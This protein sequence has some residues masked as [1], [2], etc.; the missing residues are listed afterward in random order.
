[1]NEAMLRR[2]PL[3]ARALVGLLRLGFKVGSPLSHS[4]ASRV[5]LRFFLKPPK[6][7]LSRWDR[8]AALG[9]RA[10]RIEVSGTE[11]KLLCFGPEGRKLVLL[12]HGWGGRGTHMG[13]FV[14]P[15]VERGYRVIL[16][17]GPAHGGSGG[18]STD[19]FAYA[20]AIAEIAKRF[21]PVEAIIGHSFGAACTVLAG[22]E[23]RLEVKRL[24][25]VGCFADA[26]F[27]TE[28]FGKLLRIP[29]KVVHGMRN[30]LQKRYDDRWTWEELA[31]SR[32]I[33]A[34]DVPVLF[35]HDQDDED[36]PV[37]QAVALQKAA[38]NA[39]IFIT[40][41]KGH[42]GITRDQGAIG[43]ALSFICAGQS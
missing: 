7:R 23:H 38:R 6:P 1:M 10:E 32:L 11:L 28:S 41:G 19:M 39:Q 22:R 29:P 13:G 18:A 40:Q 21:G 34:V 2:S 16:F 33:G 3:R 30:L 8:E 43:E 14:K 37:T 31:P 26:I 27:I 35:M 5:A 24:V 4:A 12:V 36:V 17:D 9:G 25:L 20:N 42:R 15:L